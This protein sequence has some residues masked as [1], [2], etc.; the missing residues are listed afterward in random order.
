VDFV[1]EIEG[2]IVPIEVKSKT[3]RRLKSL[4]MLMES[5]KL[6]LGLRISQLP[7]QQDENILSLPLYM[8]FCLF[9]N[10]KRIMGE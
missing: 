2:D 6:P 5:K 1:V 7:L 4:L 10:Y 3:S 9:E 8:V